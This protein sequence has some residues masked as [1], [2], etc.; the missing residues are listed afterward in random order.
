M[1]ENEKKA[2]EVETGYVVLK[3]TKSWGTK[4]TGDLETYHMSTAKALI[5]KKVAEIKE[6]LVEYFPENI[7]K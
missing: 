3:F 5:A 6:K 2:K 1:A 7:S 4:K